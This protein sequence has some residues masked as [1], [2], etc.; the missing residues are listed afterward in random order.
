V[1]FVQGGA[2]AL[3]GGAQAPAAGQA[4]EGEEGGP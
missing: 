2:P 3:R 4:D 1:F